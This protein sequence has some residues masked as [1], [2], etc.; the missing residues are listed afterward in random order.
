MST[1]LHGK[2][3]AS[4]VYTEF[5]P[6]SS[7]DEVLH[8]GCGA[9]VQILAY[10]KG[11]G[12]RITCCDIQELRV[13]TTLSAAHRAGIKNIEGVVA[14]LEALPFTDGT[15]DKIIAIDIIQHVRHP[16]KVLAEFLRV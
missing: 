6:V 4:R 7:D 5:F 9:G 1:M 11:A 13:Q 14:D 3:I 16:K 12:R 8:A 2:V 15:F 10:G